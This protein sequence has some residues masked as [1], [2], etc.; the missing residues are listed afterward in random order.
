MNQTMK[1]VI[2]IA[3]HE[4]MKTVLMPA[5]NITKNEIEWD[6]IEIKSL[7]GGQRTAIA[8]A[9][10]I[11]TGN[12]VETSNGMR[13]PFE[14]FRSMDRDLQFSIIGALAVLA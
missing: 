10:A 5:I 2:R 11:W 4:S 3:E 8:W 9:Y 1:A 13:D 7:S 12:Q 14:G 6:K